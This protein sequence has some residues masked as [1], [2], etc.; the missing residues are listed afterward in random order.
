MAQTMTQK[1]QKRLKREGRFDF[2]QMR[3]GQSVE[4]STL[5]QRTK[6]KREF[7]EAK[8]RKHKQHAYD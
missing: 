2:T 7:I 8:E 4:I 5:T 1:L 3:G 6:S